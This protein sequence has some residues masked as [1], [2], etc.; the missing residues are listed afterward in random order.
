MEKVVVE[1]ELELP[2]TKTAKGTQPPPAEHTSTETEPAVWP[3]MVSILLLK[4]VLMILDRL[5]MLYGILP[6]EIVKLELCPTKS[7]RLFWLIERAPPL[8]VELTVATTWTQLMPFCEQIF[9][10]AEPLL[11]AY[12]ERVLPEI[13]ACTAVEF[14]LEYTS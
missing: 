12:K 2:L 7:Q 3:V 13:F 4:E 11:L 10:V 6:P 8:D 1:L 5:L 9:I 14:E